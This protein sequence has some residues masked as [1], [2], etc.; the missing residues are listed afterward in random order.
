MVDINNIVVIG[1]KVLIKPEETINK[2]TS[3]LYLPP[4]VTEKERVRGGYI[5]KVGPGY[6]VASPIDENESWKDAGAVKYIP[7]QVE[8]GDFAL[9]SR[10]SGIEIEI[11]DEKYLIVPQSAILMVFRDE[12][13]F[14]F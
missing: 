8:E 11:K 1:D 4:G 12:E 14:N 2:T 13:L 3:G 5:I 6:P 10:N 7:L 9:F